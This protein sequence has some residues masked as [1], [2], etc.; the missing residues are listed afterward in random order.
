MRSG[1]GS[2]CIAWLGNR[3]E[4]QTVKMIYAVQLFL[5][6]GF[7]TVLNQLEVREVT[8]IYLAEDHLLLETGYRDPQIHSHSATHVLVGL[9][10]DMRLI[11][12]KENILCC[13]AL[14]S[15]G[16]VHTVDSLGMPLLVLLLDVTSTVSEQIQRLETLDGKT[17]ERIALSYRTLAAGNPAD[18][19][20][21]FFMEVMVLL[22]MKGSGSRITDERIIHAMRFAKE[23][24]QDEV[25]AG[26]ASEA[27][28]LAAGFSARH[29]LPQPIKRCS[30]L[31]QAT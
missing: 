9:H 6:R 22:K 8:E 29:I 5:F 10:G 20:E 13:G 24:L 17:A 2:G 25:T 11:T 12:E 4:I 23:H 19:Y 15:S 28:S 7:F 3:S 18:G 14:L 26:E 27:A 31:P 30:A 1:R 21:K 16:T